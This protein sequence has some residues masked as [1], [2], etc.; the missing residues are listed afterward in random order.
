MNTTNYSNLKSIFKKL[1]LNGLPDRPYI[2]KHFIS[3]SFFLSR[4][5]YQRH[6]ACRCSLPTLVD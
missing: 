4:H 1:L 2:V 5:Q 6:N 3:F